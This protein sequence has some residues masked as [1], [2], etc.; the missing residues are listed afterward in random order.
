MHS[1][2]RIAPAHKAHAG[3]GIRRIDLEVERGQ[4]VGCL[5]DVENDGGHL[6]D[7]LHVA[8]IL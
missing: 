7:R 1:H 3:H 2:V 5:N 6:L 8:L 4:L